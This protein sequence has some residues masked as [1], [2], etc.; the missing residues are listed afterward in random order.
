MQPDF[1]R[2]S[3]FRTVVASGGVIAAARELHKSPS[4]VTYDLQRLERLLGAKLFRKSGRRL[5]LTPR[6]QALA[7][8]IERAYLDLQHAW[9]SLG[10]ADGQE[11]L[12]IACVSG[13]GR[14]RLVPRLMQLLPRDRPVEVLF[15]TASGVQALLETG[16]VAL[17]VSYRPLVTSGIASVPLGEEELALVGPKSR[18]ATPA[19]EAI[20]KLPFVTYE[21]FEYVFFRWFETHRIPLPQ[22]WN[23]GDHFDELE[24]ALESVA[25]GRG[26]CVVPLDSALGRAYRSRLR[27]HRL[28]RHACS[29]E[30]HLVGSERELRSEDAALLRI[31]ALSA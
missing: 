17:G 21:E 31:A 8:S 9:E 16:R 14:Y 3:V 5:A 27:V 29:N 19:P 4:A 7:A 22:P 13:F 10:E 23:R 2:L 6:G 18:R 15:R 25:N 24:E 1:K 20:P 12:R 30:I 11:P 26:W 28:K